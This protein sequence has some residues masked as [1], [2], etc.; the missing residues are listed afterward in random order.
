MKLRNFLLVCFLL[1]ILTTFAVRTKES[2]SGLFIDTQ[3]EGKS[4]K[5]EGVY[6]PYKRTNYASE[7]DYFNALQGNNM[8]SYDQ[9]VNESGS[10]HEMEDVIREQEDNKLNV[11]HVLNENGDIVE[12]KTATT[13]NIPTYY[14]PG[15]F[16]YS[17]S[18]YIPNYEDYTKLSKVKTIKNDPK[19]IYDFKT[20]PPVQYLQSYNKNDLSSYR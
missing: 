19:Y 5:E 13:Q 15:S 9:N 10:F 20:R 11:M 14:K 6:I 2:F 18:T 17:A 8:Y 7:E 3:E 12:I 4:K 16:T 1:G